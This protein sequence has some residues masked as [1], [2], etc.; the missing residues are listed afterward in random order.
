MR[1]GDWADN[2]KISPELRFKFYMPRVS[3]LIFP[4]AC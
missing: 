4:A 3:Q 2:K 1:L